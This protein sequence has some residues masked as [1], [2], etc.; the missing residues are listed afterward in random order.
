MLMVS[1]VGMV[2][3][4]SMYGTKLSLAGDAKS[5]VVH[6]WNET[7]NIW[8]QLAPTSGAIC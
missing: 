6:G 7:V 8:C 1:I 3:K 4:S 5:S 2:A